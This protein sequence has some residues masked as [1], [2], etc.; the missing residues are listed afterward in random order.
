MRCPE[1][2]SRIRRGLLLCPECGTVIEETQ[3]ARAQTPARGIFVVD[4]ATAERA[5]ARPSWRRAS[6]ILFWAAGSTG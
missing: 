1:C 6:L 2:N 5:R 4:S 3:P